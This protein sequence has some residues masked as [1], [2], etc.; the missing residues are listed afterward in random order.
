MAQNQ[1]AVSATQRHQQAADHEAPATL[2]LLRAKQVETLRALRQALIAN[3]I[4][5][6]DEQAKALC[7]PRSTTWFVL[8]SNYKC[9]GLNAAQVVRMLRSQRLP[10]NVRSVIVRYVHERSIGAYGHTA[11]MRRKFAV[12]LQKLG[13]SSFVVLPLQACGRS[14]QE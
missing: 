8:Q 11:V 3:G 1:L 9:R 4:D 14:N 5:S 10:E 7:L 13:W 12:R 2:E 6:I